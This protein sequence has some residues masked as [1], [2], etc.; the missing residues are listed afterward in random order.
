MI[1]WDAEWQAGQRLRPPSGSAQWDARAPSFAR[2]AA[3]PGY[4]EEVLRLLSPEPTWTVLDVGCGGGTLA[5]PLARRVASVTAVDFSPAMLELLR[6]RCVEDAVQNVVPVLGSWE[7]DWDLLGIGEHDLVVASRSLAVDDL[8]GALAKVDRHARRRACVSAPVGDGPRDRRV[9]EAAGRVFTSR[10][11]YLVVVGL[12]HSMGIHADVA[13]IG[14]DEWRVHASTEEAMRA[15]A[16]MLPGPTAQELERLRAF[17]RASLVAH[18]GGWR[19]PAPRSIRWAI[20][21]WTKDEAPRPNVWR[22][23]HGRGQGGRAG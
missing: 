23:I 18:E 8:R 21:S 22:R 16:W 5:L 4:A 11:D 14:L 13:L 3:E 6:A 17:L 15:L 12:L 9:V 7:D 20:I 10:P 1:D 19:L 2:G